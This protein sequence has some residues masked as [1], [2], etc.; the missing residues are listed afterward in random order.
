MKD[1]I[2]A[3]RN[4]PGFPVLL[5]CKLVI[6]RRESRFEYSSPLANL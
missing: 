2:R 3:Q 6:R 1:I 4:E 5:S